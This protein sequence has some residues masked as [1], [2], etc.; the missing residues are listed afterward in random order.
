[1]CQNVLRFIESNGTFDP[2]KLTVV[3]YVLGHANQGLG[4][5]REAQHWYEQSRAQMIANDGKFGMALVDLNLINIAQA[6]G[7][8]K[9]ALHL[10]HGTIDVLAQHLGGKEMMHVIEGYLFLNRFNDAR[11]LA[12]KVIG[13]H[14]ASQENDDLAFTLLQLAKAEVALGDF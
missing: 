7:R 14:P 12:Q 2:S 9:R 5:L 13:Q 1:K 10:L 4:N 6:Q 11:E 3:Y 8:H